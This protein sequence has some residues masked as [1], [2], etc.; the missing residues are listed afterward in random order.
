MS[1][2]RSIALFLFTLLLCVSA[3]AQR[4]TVSGKL[5]DESTG[6]VLTSATIT[7]STSTG[8]GYSDFEGKF[9]AS[10]EVGTHSVDI[11]LMGYT[12]MTIPGVVVTEGGNTDLGLLKLSNSA[13]E[14]VKGGV[15]IRVKKSTTSESALITA[16]KKSVKNNGR[17]QQAGD[18]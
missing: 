7:T 11:K 8:G 10:F 2:I 15:T 16:Q 12:T 13:E 3:L 9:A 1:M 17:D 18:G 14:A 6:E 4:G 5:V